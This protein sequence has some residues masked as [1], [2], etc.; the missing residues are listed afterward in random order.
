M[1]NIYEIRRNGDITESIVAYFE[2]LFRLQS[3]RT[4]EFFV[5]TARV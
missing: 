4:E 5:S 2:V 1:I 3:G